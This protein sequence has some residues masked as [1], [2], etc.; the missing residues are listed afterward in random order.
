MSDRQKYDFLIFDVDNTLLDFSC[1]FRTAQ[2]SVA[3]LPGIECTEGFRKADDR[4]GWK[5]WKEIRLDDTDDEDVQRNYH[6]Y[7]HAYLKAHY[8]YLLEELSIQ[9]D[10]VEL[11]ECYLKSLPLSAVPMEDDTVSVL[12]ELSERYVIVLATNGMSDAQRKRTE[13]FGSCIH[14]MFVSEE[15]GV[16]KPSDAFFRY[17]LNDLGCLPERCLMV[18]DSV[19]NDMIGAKKAGMDVCFYDPA[20]KGPDKDIAVDHVIGRINELRQILL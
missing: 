15:M 7:Y 14:R 11:V 10:P 3:A 6:K 12:N 19:E 20:H 2:K 16:I 4:A 8:Q 13:I 1:V 5:A 9:G 18:G 17:M